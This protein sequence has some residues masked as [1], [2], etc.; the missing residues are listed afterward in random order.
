ME[1][2]NNGTEWYIVV[3]SS[4][5]AFMIGIFISCIVF[6]CRRKFKRRKPQPKR[7]ITKCEVEKTYEELDLTKMNTEDNYQSLTV[8]QPAK[9]DNGNEDDSTYTELGQTREAEKAYQSLTWTWNILVFDAGL[10]R[11]SQ[12]LLELLEWSEDKIYKT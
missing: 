9:K 2:R 12:Q 10:C 6:R 8:N 5:S 4:V 11:D 3:V 7:E 1:S